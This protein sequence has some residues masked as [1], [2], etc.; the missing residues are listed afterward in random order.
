[1]NTN[2]LM[3]LAAGVLEIFW[4]SGLNYSST[5]W[6]WALTVIA[7]IISFTLVILATRTLPIGT[8][9]A[10]FAGIGTAGTVVVETLFFN[11]P[12][13]W[14]KVLL[15]GTLLLGVIGLKLLSSDVKE[16]EPCTGQL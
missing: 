14:M 13:S 16:E 3:V 6:Q 10:V 7:I 4:V 9:Y 15:I 1:M 2:W 12:F 11:E 8:V 5:F